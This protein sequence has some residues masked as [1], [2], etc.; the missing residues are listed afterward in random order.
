MLQQSWSSSQAEKDKTIET[1][2][3][4]VSEM[5][6]LSKFLHSP[7][8]QFFHLDNGDNSKKKTVKGFIFM[9]IR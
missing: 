2:A 6:D 9:E 1:T 3:F 5:C 7:E 4:E 8:S